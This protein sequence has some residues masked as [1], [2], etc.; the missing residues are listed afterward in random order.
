MFFHEQLAGQLQVL[1]AA[2][3]E[4]TG[5]G[6]CRDPS[7]DHRVIYAFAGRRRHDPRGVACQ[8]NVF[9]VV[10]PVKRMQR[11]R[12]A[13]TP[14]RLTVGQT[15]GCTQIGGGLFQIH[16]GET[17]THPDAGALPMWENPA[18]EIR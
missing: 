6:G 10:P 16:I 17:C 4:R 14:Y 5:T 13:F 9:A 3:G 2:R 11:D 12:C 8:N 1:C 7:R 18:V 15:A